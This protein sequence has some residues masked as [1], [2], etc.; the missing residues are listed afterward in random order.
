VNTTKKKNL[1]PVRTKTEYKAALVRIEELIAS[2][3]KKGTTAYEDL[4]I[5]GTS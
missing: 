3:P 5:I 2:N 4:D 1:K